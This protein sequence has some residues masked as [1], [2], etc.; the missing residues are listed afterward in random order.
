MKATAAGGRHA[1]DEKSTERLF[2]AVISCTNIKNR[3]RNSP[4]TGSSCCVLSAPW[5]HGM[6]QQA[7]E[8]RR[9]IIKQNMIA[10]R[11]YRLSLFWLQSS[12]EAAN[13]DFLF[14]ILLSLGPA[15]TGACG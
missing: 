7:Y 12:M 8:D 14:P 1:A 6:A 4:V 2:H 10:K 5:V 13:F 15:C 9:R 3:N 11:V